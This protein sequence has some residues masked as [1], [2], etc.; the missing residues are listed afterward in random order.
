VNL[1]FVPGV[2]CSLR[3]SSPALRNSASQPSRRADQIAG[4]GLIKYVGRPQC[5]AFCLFFHHQ[6]LLRP[7]ARLGRAHH[8]FLQSNDTAGESLPSFSDSGGCNWQR[9]ASKT[10][11][12]TDESAGIC[13]GQACLALS[14]P[15]HHSFDKRRCATAGAAAAAAA[16]AAGR[17]LTA[18]SNKQLHQSQPSHA[19][20]HTLQDATARVLPG[21]N[22]LTSIR[23]RFRMPQRAVVLAGTLCTGDMRRCR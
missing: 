21:M 16:G 11:A 2:L 22:L 15:R 10:Y 3:R 23:T 17:L 9:T 1:E 4:S 6:T 20:T 19:H 8:R 18:E 13:T 5:G 12:H 14:A 7:T